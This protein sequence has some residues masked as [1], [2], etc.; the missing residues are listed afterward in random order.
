MGVMSFSGSVTFD[1][2]PDMCDNVN[3]PDRKNHN[4]Y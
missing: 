4:L 3:E 1:Y 2:S